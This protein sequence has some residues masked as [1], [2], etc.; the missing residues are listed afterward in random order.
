MVINNIQT[1]YTLSKT[2]M[3]YANPDYHPDWQTL[4]DMAQAEIDELVDML[5]YYPEAERNPEDYNAAQQDL[6]S[7]QQR[8]SKAVLKQFRTIQDFATHIF[9]LVLS[10][11]AYPLIPDLSHLKSKE[12]AFDFLKRM[13]PIIKV[14]HNIK[15]YSLTPDLDGV[16]ELFAGSNL[17][18]QWVGVDEI[19]PHPVPVLVAYERQNDQVLISVTIDPKEKSLN[20]I[21]LNQLM[22]K[23]ANQ[24]QQ[25]TFTGFHPDALHFFLHTPPEMGEKEKF[26]QVE[27]I[28]NQEEGLYHSPCLEFLPS[29]PSRIQNL[30]F[31]VDDYFKPLSLAREI[32]PL[33]N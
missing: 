18:A 19:R 9:H 30:R 32:E 21:E 27:F 25:K 29:I 8:L 20:Y 2:R 1:F 26:I 17:K 22:L 5:K 4:V 24:L 3:P 10:E 13:L 11:D 15:K 28:Y 31:F 33:L 16:E 12:E 7:A 14:E 6:L 23:L